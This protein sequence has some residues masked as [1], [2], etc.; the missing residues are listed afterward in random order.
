VKLTAD[1]LLHPGV[2]LGARQRARFRTAATQL[3]GASD[4][5]FAQRLAALY[6]LFGLR[7]VLILLNEFLPVR[8]ER[9]VAAGETRRWG[10][11]K[12]GQLGKAR[13]LLTRVVQEES[14]LLHA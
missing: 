14:E 8:W 5:K 3:Y 1:V 2:P 4:E 6:P 13:A 9:R 12:A 7:W 10:D 11:V